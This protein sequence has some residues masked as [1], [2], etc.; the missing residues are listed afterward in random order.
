MNSD[1]LEPGGWYQST[2]KPVS[3][4]RYEGTASDGAYV[5]SRFNGNSPETAG[6]LVSKIEI[7]NLGELEPWP[8]P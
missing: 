4:F 5:F 3:L 1:D 7:F 6:E 8:K 2:S